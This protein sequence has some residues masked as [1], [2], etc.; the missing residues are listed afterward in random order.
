MELIELTE[1]TATEPQ[2]LSELIANRTASANRA[3]GNG[4]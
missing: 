2:E 3:N 1:L 4:A